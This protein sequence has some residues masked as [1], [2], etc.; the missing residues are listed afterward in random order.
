M[1]SL[2]K[3]LNMIW[4]SILSQVFRLAICTLEMCQVDMQLFLTNFGNCPL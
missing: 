3:H 4:S 1:S 2:E